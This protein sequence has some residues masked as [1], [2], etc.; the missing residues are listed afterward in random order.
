L[1]RTSVPFFAVG[2]IIRR[3]TQNCTRVHSIDYTVLYRASYGTASL[4]HCHTDCCGIGSNCVIP[5]SICLK[6]VPGTVLGTRPF[7]RLNTKETL[8]L[9]LFLRHKSTSFTVSMIP[10]PSAGANP[11]CTVYYLG[12]PTVI[13]NI[14]SL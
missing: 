11:R 7:T 5:T 14:P 8:Q 12:V 6:R 3:I 1:C 4:Y 10:V 13:E 2:L 9:E